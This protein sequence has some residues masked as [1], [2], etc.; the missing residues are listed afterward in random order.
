[1]VLLGKWQR[2]AATFSVPGGDPPLA[3]AALVQA[4]AAGPILAA[5]KR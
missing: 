4:N 1:M 5:A 2:E 3:E